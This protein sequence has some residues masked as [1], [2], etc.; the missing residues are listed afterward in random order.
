MCYCSEW[1]VWQPGL[2]NSDARQLLINR[3]PVS[4][5]TGTANTHTQFMNLHKQH[6][7]NL[8]TIPSSP[9][10]WHLLRWIQAPWLW[11]DPGMRQTQP[12][13]LFSCSVIGIYSPQSSAVTFT[14]E[15]CSVRLKCSFIHAQ[16]H[17]SQSVWEQHTHVQIPKAW[18][19]TKR[20]SH[21]RC[22]Q[23]FSIVSLLTESSTA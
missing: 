4:Q 10:L 3:K 5:Q 13:A 9:N 8:F 6:I 15:K 16:A 12:L 14:L 2:M 17:M 18:R 22:W 20:S 23:K 21:E 11:T 19:K 1:E 7:H